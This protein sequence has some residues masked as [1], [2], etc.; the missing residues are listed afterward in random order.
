[1][2]EMRALF[3]SLP[4]AAQAHLRAAAGHQKTVNVPKLA[5]AVYPYVQTLEEAMGVAD[6]IANEALSYPEANKREAP[7]R[8]TSVRTDVPVSVSWASD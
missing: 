4:S 1:M 6:F 7:R 5:R 3:L 2:D 8:S